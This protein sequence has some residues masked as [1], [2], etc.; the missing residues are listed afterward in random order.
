MKY[1]AVVQY[2]LHGT[3]AHM[4]IA[5]D[6]SHQLTLSSLR[7]TDMQIKTRSNNPPLYM[8]SAHVPIK[9]GNDQTETSLEYTAILHATLFHSLYYN[10]FL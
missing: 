8:T 5:S 3:L 1:H 6:I 9:G 7:L 2:L 10:L 4:A